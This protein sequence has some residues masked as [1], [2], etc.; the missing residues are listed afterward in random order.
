M[1]TYEIPSFEKTKT[2]AEFDALV[3]AALREIK[4]HIHDGVGLGIRIDGSNLTFSGL[5][6]MGEVGQ[7]DAVSFRNNEPVDNPARRSK[8]LCEEDRLKH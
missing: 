8:L 7:V 5:N 3:I 2:R 4:D 1:F 6:A